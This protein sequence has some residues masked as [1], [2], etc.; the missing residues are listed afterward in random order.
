MTRELNC[1]ACPL[2]CLITVEYEGKDVKSVTG[3]TCKRG[4]T[5]A[6]QEIVNPERSIHSTVRVT[7]GHHPVVPCKTSVPIPK[8][9]IFDVMA[10][11]NGVTV[12][13]PVAIGQVLIPDVCGTGA[14]IVATN[15]DNG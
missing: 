15:S 2:G 13:A 14:D 8:E 6:R 3:N 11:I 5:Y 1:I 12:A 9:K 10:E 7:G 4:E